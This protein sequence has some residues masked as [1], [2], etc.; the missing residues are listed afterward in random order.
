MLARVK[1][2]E[3]SVTLNQPACVI[4]A[5]VVKQG[6]VWSL[7]PCQATGSSQATGSWSAGVRLSVVGQKGNEL[8]WKKLMFY[9][10]QSSSIETMQCI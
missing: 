7:Y 3:Q 9:G 8:L 4:A 5:A 6:A 2:S 1:Y 10:P